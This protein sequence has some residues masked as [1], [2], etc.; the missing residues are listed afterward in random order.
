MAKFDIWVEGS[1]SQ[2]NKCGAQII[3][4][5]VEAENFKAAVIK[6]YN[7]LAEVSDVKRMYGELNTS[8]ERPTLW[9]CGLYDNYYD[10]RKS[11]G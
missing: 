3:A 8:E 1:E 5:G 7:A 4:C 10:A 6:W 11:F 9:G 2:G